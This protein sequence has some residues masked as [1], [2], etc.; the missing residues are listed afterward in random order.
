[1]ITRHE[2]LISL[3]GVWRLLL[4]DPRGVEWLDNSIDGYWKSFFCAL[5]IL[6]GYIAWIGFAP[7]DV[8][9]GVGLLRIISVE[10]IG[11]V[12]GWVSW[13]LAMA[14]VAS[15]VSRDDNYIRY[16]VAYNWATVIQITLFLLVLLL[17]FVL[18]LPEGVVAVVTFCVMAVL[19]YYH[20]YILRVALD[21]SSGAAAAM[22]FGEYLLSQFVRSIT[23]GILHG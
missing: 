18:Q 23:I 12:I 6:P 14:Y 15:A 4:R 22:V 16:I 10:G 1:V 19:L 13:P 2:V 21:V 20:W 3:Y 11:Y 9:E 8:Y 17:L 5:L 7:S